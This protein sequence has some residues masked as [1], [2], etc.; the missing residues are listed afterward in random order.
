MLNSHKPLPFRRRVEDRYRG[1]LDAHRTITSDLS[2]GSMLE[3]LVDA[4][5]NLVGAGY[6][7]LAVIG[8]DGGIEQFV[9]H[10]LADDDVA[11][12]GALPK[13]RGRLGA[14]IAD[15]VPVRL[16]DLAADTRAERFP[17]NHPPLH[18]F[19]G[20]P[21]LVR[22]EVF[23]ELYLAAPLRG[24]FDEA[25]E[26]VVTAL[27]ATAATAIA[28]ARLYDAARRSREWLNASGDIARA[29]LAN[30]DVDILLDVVS[31]ARRV[32]EADYG[33]LILPTGDG[34]LEVTA[35]V[36][37]GADDIRG[38]VFDPQESAMGHAIVAGETIAMADMMQ[39][40]K[41]DHP[42]VHNFGP[43]MIA[44]LLDSQ[45]T[46]GAV[47][48]MRTAD[49]VAFTDADLEMATTFAT[50]VALALQYADARADAEWLRVLEDRHKI[51]QDLHDNVMQR[52]FATGVGLQG[53]ANL[54]LDGEIAARLSRHIADLDDTIEQIRTRVFGLREPGESTAR[55][56]PGTVPR[57]PDDPADSPT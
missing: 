11:R 43:A 33:G 55:R 6:G 3:H 22:G 38:L 35:T 53:L 54:P 14:L 26:E 29:L 13:G 50:Q 1:L 25:D 46:R 45:G 16:D 21:I 34:Q 52:L 4:T 40:A 28:N 36:G 39:W 18:A 20:V 5:C 47:L 7:A 8:P 27:A 44:P 56:P 15:L 24:R 32:A 51:A 48:L 42:N 9:H 49:R 19:L 2:L 17:P 30:A 12:I 41:A 57:V 37:L 10:G 31:R 23:G